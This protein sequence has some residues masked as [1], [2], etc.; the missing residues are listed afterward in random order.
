MKKKDQALKPEWTILKLIQWATS[1]F[2]S[3]QVETPR[4]D[5]EILLAYCLG[6]KRVDLYIR[7]DQPL[8]QH[9]LSVFKDL[10]KRRSKRE[11][12]AYITGLKEFWSIDFNVT[13]DVLIPRPD[14]ECLVETALECISRKPNSPQKNIFE[15][16]TG[17]GAVIIALCSEHPEHT[18]FA[19]DLSVK[20]LETAK[21]NAKKYGLEKTIRF[22]SGDWM[23]PI[24]PVTGC[25]DLIISNPPYIP[26]TVIETL[27]PEISKFEPRMALDGDM[28]GLFALR[29]L[30]SSAPSF[31]RPGGSLILEIGHDQKAPVNKLVT[32]CGEYED[33]FFRKDYG[34][35]YRVVQINKR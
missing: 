34:G 1:Y 14:T 29:H 8:S 35:N 15:L 16:G 31:L 3:H 2:T 28:D 23:S 27:Q 30:I 25:F 4:V 19:S 20:A 33:W 24:N 6:I 17:S 11:P 13:P 21:T 32:A 7:F 9:E 22:F 12:V 10:I 26:T 18:F 5:A